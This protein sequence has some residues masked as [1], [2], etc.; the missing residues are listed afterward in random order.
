MHP[1]IVPHVVI[2]PI[3]IHTLS[4]TLT[5]HLTHWG[6]LALLITTIPLSLSLSLYLGHFLSQHPFIIISLS[7]SLFLDSISTQRRSFPSKPVSM[8]RKASFFLS[9]FH[10]EA[11]DTATQSHAVIN[12]DGDDNDDDDNDDN[13]DN[14][15]DDGSMWPKSSKRCQ[16]CL[17]PVLA[18]ATLQR[19]SDEVQK[20]SNRFHQKGFFAV[21]IL[22]PIY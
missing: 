9:F 5:L 15:D 2:L 1:Y 12:D 4:L 13:D 16:K 18:A 14:D 6:I 21:S 19:Q 17:K 7:L 20:K 8:Q 11:D 22:W 3:R 10:K